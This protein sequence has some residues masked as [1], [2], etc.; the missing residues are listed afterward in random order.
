MG[1]RLRLGT[2]AAGAFPAGPAMPAVVESVHDTL[3]RLTHEGR[4]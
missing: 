4:G 2:G 1:L 3:V